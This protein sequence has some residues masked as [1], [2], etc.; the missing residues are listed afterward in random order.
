[1]EQEYF[2]IK[3][4]PGGEYLGTEVLL[5]D[6]VQRFV[7]YDCVD[8]LCLFSSE[9]SARAF[10]E[11]ME[12]EISYHGSEV[13]GVLAEVK[14]GKVRLLLADFPTQALLKFIETIDQEYIALDPDTPGQQVWDI[15]VFEEHVKR[16]L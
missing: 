5:S 15:E 12:L 1:M 11:S 7:G 14:T 4:D 10:A 8:A 6:D 2:V 9:D 13:S 3:Y 16:S